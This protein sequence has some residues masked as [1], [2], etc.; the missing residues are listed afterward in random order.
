MLKQAIYKLPHG[1]EVIGEYALTG[2]N[3]YVRVRIRPHTFFPNVPVIGGGCLVRHSRAVMASK[4]GRALSDDEVVH[5]VNE[6]RSDDSPGNLELTTAA[7]HNTHHKTGS[8]H[9]EQSKQ[10]IAVGLCLAISEGRRLPPP[11][12]N[13]CGRSHQPESRRKLSATRKAL[14]ASG[15][16]SKPAPPNPLGRV[17]S[18]ET[19][20]KIRQSKLAYWAKKRNHQ[21]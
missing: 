4:L 8:R 5:H 18:T 2:L 9:S 16:I 7:E 12:T 10:R 14:I 15:A 13:W 6:N 11:A 20:K 3:R 19:R 1:I 17:M 21:A